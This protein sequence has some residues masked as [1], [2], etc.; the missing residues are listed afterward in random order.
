MLVRRCAFLVLEPGTQWT[1]DVMA[2]LSGSNG[3]AAV[4]GWAARAPHLREPVAVSSGEIDLLGRIPD[5]LWMAGERIEG[6]GAQEILHSLLAKG[7]VMEAADADAAERVAD[8][9]LRQQAW[10]GWAAH[11]HAASRWQG[12][13]SVRD[14]PRNTQGMTLDEL[15][16]R[17]GPIPTH[18]PQ[19]CASE[20]R[21]QLPSATASPLSALLSARATCRNYAASSLPLVD[22]AH[23]LGM[24]FAAQGV[25][26]LSQ[27]CFAVKKSAPSGG[28]LHP[29]EA[30]VIARNVGGLAS[31]VYHYEAGAHA[32]GTLQ[33]LTQEEADR[34]A[35]IAVAGQQWFAQAPV[36]IVLAA[37]FYRNFWKYRNHPKAYRVLNLDAGHLSQTLFLA[38]G[39]LGY[40]AFITAAINEIDLE[41]ALG[42][43]G[44]QEGP[45]AV[46][47][48]GA[49]A[50]RLDTVEFDPQGTV[51][52]ADGSR[53]A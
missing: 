17:Y 39:E 15:A 11:L 14:D 19:R 13:D 34:L 35:L 22:L 9:R 53:C 46:L 43:D 31:G 48:F 30:Y 4:A 8:A 52:N 27:D 32:L 29:I 47:G 25:Q 45:L 36:Q 2:M 26:Q 28:A 40:G 38:A 16:R 6:I 23:V 24:V 42:L 51:W 49:R 12:V 5:E 18:F 21:L 3:I 37:R 44:M 41:Q 33:A 10:F 50:E 20:R 1:L 7:L